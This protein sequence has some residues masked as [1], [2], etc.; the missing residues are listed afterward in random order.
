MPLTRFVKMCVLL[1]LLLM[2]CTDTA[3][4]EQKLKD[5]LFMLRS[6]IDGYTIN[7]QAEPQSLDDLVTAGYLKEVPVDPFTGRK[8][9]WI[10]TSGL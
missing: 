7:R 4:R 3:Q 9:T 2:P 6:A 1:P 5:D 8:D 10:W